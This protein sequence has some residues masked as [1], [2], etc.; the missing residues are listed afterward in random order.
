MPSQPFHDGRSPRKTT[1]NSATSTTLSLS[2]GATSVAGPSF[3]RAGNSTARRAGAKPGE[4]AGN[5][6][7]FAEDRSGV[8][9]LPGRETGSAT[10]VINTNHGA[11]QG[12]GRSELMAFDADFGEG[13]AV[14]EP[15]R[16]R[17]GWPRAARS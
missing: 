12:G 7:L 17:R 16:L 13:I 8:A 11:D 6:Q 2:I 5:S 10:G 4:Q 15:R 9:E 1:P 3:R 14:S